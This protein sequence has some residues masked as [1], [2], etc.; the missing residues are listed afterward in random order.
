MSSLRALP[1]LTRLAYATT[2]GRA[3][4][5]SAAEFWKDFEQPWIRAILDSS[6]KANRQVKLP[7][8]T[9]EL[10]LQ[11]TEISD[12]T[13][14]SNAPIS[15]L[16]IG[17][18]AVTNLAPLRGMRLKTFHLFGTKVSDL[19]PLQ[20]MPI[21]NLNLAGVKVT[22]LSALRG[23]PLTSLRLHD[24]AAI[25][26]LTHLADMSMLKALTLPS[27]AKD[28][29]FL[30]ATN[31]FPNLKRL[32]YREDRG[33]GYRPAQ[34]SAEFWEEFD[35]RAKLT[36]LFKAGFTA[37]NLAR[38]PDGTWEV[39]LIGT[40]IRDLTIL[41][42]TPISV[43]LIGGTGVTNLVPLRGMML[44]R[45]WL[46]DT[47]VSDLLPLKGMPIEELNL[48]E[49]KVSDLS[50]LR[51]MPLTSLRL[52]YC[53]AITN[54][55]HLA[56]MSMLKALTLPPNA[57]DFEFLRDTNKFPNL[58]R[59]SLKEDRDNGYR[60]AQSSEEF[61]K[62]FDQQGWRTA[63]TK[64]GFTP[65]NLARLSD[66]TWEVDLSGTAIRDLTI[67]SNAPISVLWLGATAVTNLA[68]L[69]GM[70]LK[71]LYLYNT[72]VVD[73][74]PLQGMPIEALNLVAT[75]VADL[76]VLRGMPLRSLR[77]H[78]CTEITNLSPLAGATT[79]KDLTLP[80][81]AKNFEF[82]R[83]LPSLERLSYQDDPLNNFRPT[84]TA[85][86]FW[87]EYGQTNRKP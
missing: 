37:R 6:L 28:F 8:G 23:M 78:G 36:A 55:T 29:E 50:V 2:S 46:Y 76:S 25:T 59:L 80:P 13:I 39:D 5:Q 26:N 38:L 53:A 15:I 64:A 68:P 42:N 81:N 34:S 14:L 10:N 56:D 66:G 18:T 65:K 17:G 70:R 75:K 30:R 11:D 74:S 40:T 16:S 87:A 63:L 20:G 21:E 45:L 73:L 51:G 60:V 67:L 79:L 9:W 57:K 43:L 85:E 33:N 71:A 86:E 72:T 77:L 61:W 7:D 52:H 44:K 47:K 3:T 54:L 69:R 84:Q 58:K 48:S 62:E 12:L 27:N 49:T 24:G 83:S 82:L 19:S 4:T 31:K 32:S 35:Q 41:S 1:A 22:D